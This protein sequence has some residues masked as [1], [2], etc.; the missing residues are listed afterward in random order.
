MFTLYSTLLMP[1]S[2]TV[3]GARNHDRTRRTPVQHRSRE[4]VEEILRAAERLVVRDGVDA[5]TTRAVATAARVPVASVYQYF[6]DR[7]GIMAALIERHVLAMDEQLTAEVTALETFSVRTL[8]QAT[9][10][11]YV[12]GYRQRP[13]YVIIWFQGRVSPE[14][15]TFVRRRSEDL[16]TRFHAFSI[17]AGL[18]RPETGVLV[19][20]LAAEMIDAFLAVAYRDDLGGDERIIDEGIEMITSYI[21]P[22]ATTAGLDGVPAAEIA[23]RLELGTT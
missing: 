12:A 16:A 6:A 13:S 10:A 5:L 17:A 23:G 22:H 11:A 19:F 4:R 7:D 14:I 9:V 20:E 1:S 15:A 21:A 18:V 8:V 3:T 2:V